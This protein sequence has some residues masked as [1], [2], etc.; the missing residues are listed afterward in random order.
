MDVED[1]DQYDAAIAFLAARGMPFH[2]RPPQRLIV[3]TSDYQALQVAKII[4]GSSL[5]ANG[6]SGNKTRSSAKPKTRRA[7]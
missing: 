4:V 3:R 1:L 5:K 2:T 6:P 7:G